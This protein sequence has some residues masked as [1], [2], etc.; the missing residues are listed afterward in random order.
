[1]P[2][3]SGG[4]G[5]RDKY[6]KE[7]TAALARSL[8]GAKRQA[9]ALSSERKSS[10]IAGDKANT[11]RYD[12]YAYDPKDRNAANRKNKAGNI[13]ADRAYKKWYGGNDPRNNDTSMN[14]SSIDPKTKVQTNPG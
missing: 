8:V 14:Y 5:T 9:D 2:G 4:G 7:K 10:G 1:M 13:A 12:K 6:A 11:G 3:Q